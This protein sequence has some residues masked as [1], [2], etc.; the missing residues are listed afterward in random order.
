MKSRKCPLCGQRRGK[1]VC[2]LL[3]SICTLCCGTRRGRDLDCPD[4]CR[5]FPDPSLEI[6]RIF[7]DMLE[8]LL[9]FTIKEDHGWTRKAAD[10]YFSNHRREVQEWERT[11]FFGYLCYGYR[12]SGGET[13]ADRFLAMRSDLLDDNEQRALRHLKEKKWLSLFEVSSIR[14][15][16]GIHLADLIFDRDIFVHEKLGTRTFRKD[17]HVLAWVVEIEGKYVMAGSACTISPAHVDV[18]LEF[19]DRQIGHRGASATLSKEAVLGDL[20]P[21][22]VQV[23][24]TAIREFVPPTILMPDGEEM[25]LSEALYEVTGDVR[26]IRSRLAGR[27]DIR[28]I[29][30]DRFA[31][32]DPRNSGETESIPIGWIDLRIASLTLSSVSRAELER[33]KRFVSRVLGRFVRHRVDSFRTQEE[34]FEDYKRTAW[35][36]AGESYP[37]SRALPIATPAS[38]ENEKGADPEVDVIIRRWYDEHARVLSAESAAEEKRRKARDRGDSLLRDDGHRLPRLAHERI[39]RLVPGLLDLV[40]VAAARL[41]APINREIGRTLGP[42]ELIEIGE[43]ETFLQDYTMS[44]YRLSR[45]QDDALAEARLLASHIL[46]FLNYELHRKKT[47]WL[48]ESLS[49]MLLETNLDVQGAALELPFP[50][51]AIVLTD[52]TS[53]ELGVDL[54]AHDRDCAIRDLPLEIITVYLTWIPMTDHGGGRDLNVSFVFDAGVGADEWPYLL[55]RELYIRP[56]DHLDAILDSVVPDIPREDRDPLF[57]APELKKLLHLVINCVLYATS[58]HLE[59]IVLGAAP[60]TRKAAGKKKKG[61]RKHRSSR[62][63]RL[64]SDEDVFFLPGKIDISRIRA[65][66]ELERTPSGR[67]I[68]ARFM[69][70]GHWRR[71]NPDWK[72][73]SLRWIRPYWKGPEMAMVIE[74]EYRLKP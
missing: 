10:S 2:P 63:R 20:L 53:L 22:I 31:V 8:K 49:W 32:F 38:G 18:V 58:A 57:Y 29:S 74:R 66:R 54:L 9:Q 72:D 17:D 3:G 41:R 26:S 14:P 30:E 70:R 48:D 23:L 34:L 61:R 52:S 56:N 45:S 71:A 40:R 35:K 73:Q 15:D 12:D 7:P 33:G 28:S 21:S 60:S 69:V 19:I 43:I 11:I 13:G 62:P 50:S 39:A 6:R 4:D 25:T 55:S 44:Q 68:M 67:K 59:P 24:Q 27:T 64:Y 1:L 37:A 16:V 65:Y 36:K 47:F 51:L 46:Y 5:Y 42:E